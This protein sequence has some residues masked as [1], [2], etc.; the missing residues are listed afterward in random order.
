MH[1]PKTNHK[2]LVAKNRDL[3][4][5]QVQTVVPSKNKFCILSTPSNY[6]SFKIHDCCSIMEETNNVWDL[7]MAPNNHLLA[8][9]KYNTKYG[10]HC[11]ACF[12]LNLVYERQVASPVWCPNPTTLL[13]EL[14][15]FSCPN[16]LEILGDI[17]QVIS[18]I[19]DSSQKKNQ[20][21]FIHYS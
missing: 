18:S 8:I 10:Q 3:I 4:I 13:V 2:F 1:V 19:I 7:L 11:I 21:L 16:P 9:H 15:N 17:S 5:N 14:L 20:Q 12:G 6:Q